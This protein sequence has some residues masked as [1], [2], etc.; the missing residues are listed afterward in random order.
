MKKRMLKLIMKHNPETQEAEVD[1]VANN[2]Y[3]DDGEKLYKIVNEFFE[4]ICKEFS[5]ND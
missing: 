2:K 3:F 1:V 5:E 4:K